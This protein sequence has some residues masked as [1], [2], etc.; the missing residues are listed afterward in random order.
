MTYAIKAP[1]RYAQGA[2]ELANLGRS[3]KKLGDKFL[4]ICSDNNRSR[5]GAQVEESLTGQEK[6][7][8][9]TTFDGEATKE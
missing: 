5:F 9:F 3:A 1:A 6:Q 8:D 2:G 4:I 7:V